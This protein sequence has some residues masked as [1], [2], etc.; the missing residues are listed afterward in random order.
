[1]FF[2]H[3]VSDGEEWVCKLGRRVIGRFDDVMD[4]VDFAE[5][6]GTLKQP[7]QVLYHGTHG[8]VV[9]LSTFPHPELEHIS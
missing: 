5:E 6:Q 1:V 9:L 8:S 4:A 7:S 3:V 2:F